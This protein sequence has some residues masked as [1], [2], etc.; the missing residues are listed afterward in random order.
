MGSDPIAPCGRWLGPRV[1]AVTVAAVAV[2]GT[3]ATAASDGG[4][5]PTTVETFAGVARS[6]DASAGRVAWLNSAWL[7]SVRSLRSHAETTVRYTNPYQEDAVFS[8]RPPLVLEPVGALLRSIRTAGQ[9]ESSDHLILV[10]TGTTDRIQL[11]RY[12]HG[13]DAAGHYITGLAGDTTSFAYSVVNVDEVD[14]STRSQYQPTEGGVWTVTGTAG[15]RLADVTPSIVLALSAGR[16]A[17]APVDTR[18]RMHGTP[19]PAKTVELRAADSGA[20]L[21]TITLSSTVRAAALTPTTLYLLVGTRVARYDARTGSPLGT[22]A[23]PA[24]TAAQLDVANGKLAYRRTRSVDVVDAATGKLVEKVPTAGSPWTV[25]LDGSTLAWS[26]SRRVAPGPP[27][28][29]TYVTQIR[30]LPLG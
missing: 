20:L 14:T 18:T 9:F 13:Q 29:K 1:I 15:R 4:T 28:K 3:A 8:A 17:L 11:A 7:L 30:T 12:L 6:F 24:D 26:E 2:L 5:A 22:F 10:K 21:A 27:S 23:V 25:A 16:L 19:I